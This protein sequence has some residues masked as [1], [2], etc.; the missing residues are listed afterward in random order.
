[1]TQLRRE[2]VLYLDQRVQLSEDQL[3]D[4]NFDGIIN[5]LDIVATVVMITDGEGDLDQYP[6]NIRADF[7][8]DGAVNILDVVSM[9]N[10]ILGV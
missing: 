3:G 10:F 7:N 4:V 9:V 6:E 1:M 2:K 5:V 8:Q